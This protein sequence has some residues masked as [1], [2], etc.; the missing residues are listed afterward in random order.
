VRG[1]IFTYAAASFVV[2]HSVSIDLH[3][4]L[5][6]GNQQVSVWD[7]KATSTRRKWILDNFLLREAWKKRG[8]SIAWTGEFGSRRQLFDVLLSSKPMAAGSG[9][10][11]ILTAAAP[12]SMHSLAGS[13]Q[14][15]DDAARA[16]SPGSDPQKLQLQKKSEDLKLQIT[17]SR[18]EESAGL[19]D[20]LA[21]V[22]GRLQKLET[23]GEA[24]HTILQTYEPSVCLIH[25]VLGFRS[26]Y[27]TNVALCCAY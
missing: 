8:A 26:S 21:K 14:A 11:A 24:A 19:Q 27:N 13:R 10:R 3:F 6:Q 7:C 23:E 20:Q 5:F 25:V 15:S 16:V 4:S 18:P 12:L 1:L 22:E 2:S 9:R 17:A